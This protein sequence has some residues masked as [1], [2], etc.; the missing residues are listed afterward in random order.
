[1]KGEMMRCCKEEFD[2]D[3]ASESSCEGMA[4]VPEEEDA[5]TSLERLLRMPRKRR[6]CLEEDFEVTYQDDDAII[7]TRRR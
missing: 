5:A 7:M 4:G 2:V 3:F 1:M 6:M